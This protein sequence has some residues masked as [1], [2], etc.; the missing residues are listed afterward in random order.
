M[1]VDHNDTALGFFLNQLTIEQYLNQFTLPT[2]GRGDQIAMPLEG[3]EWNEL[4][5]L[6]VEAVEIVEL[7]WAFD[8]IDETDKPVPC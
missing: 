2:T 7:E 1:G 4:P 8:Q 6:E 5:H 3:V